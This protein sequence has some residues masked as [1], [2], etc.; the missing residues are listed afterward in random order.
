MNGASQRG[1]ASGIRDEVQNR[2][3]LPPIVSDRI[4]RAQI[5]V[6]SERTENLLRGKRD[7]IWGDRGTKASGVYAISYMPADRDPDSSHDITWYEA[8]HPDWVARTCAGE[9]ANSF[10]YPRGYLTPLLVA[11]ADVREYLFKDASLALGGDR[12][13][14]LGVDNLQSVNRWGRC[15]SNGVKGQYSGSRFD[16]AYVA[17]QAEWLRW[18]KSRAHSRGKCLAG[19]LHFNRGDTQGFVTLEKDL[20]IVIDEGGFTRDCRPSVLGKDWLTRLRLFATVASK[21]ALVLIDKI[22]PTA[23]EVTSSA[24]NWSVANYLLIKEDRTYLAINPMDTKG[25]LSDFPA[26][27]LKVGNALGV[28]EQDGPL[29]YRRYSSAL[30]LVNPSGGSAKFSLEGNRYTTLDGA[31]VEDSVTVAPGSALVLS[32]LSS[33]G[34]AKVGHQR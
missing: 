15:G 32:L 29:F 23:R 33:S 2:C 20:D 16:P 3:V 1:L 30:A 26:L 14:A 8:N 34:R 24:L 5:F 4:G 6:D 18:L 9:P 13:Q 28:F 27:Y 17:D 21:K 19:N 22:C 7:I 10:R 11:R 12:Y 25:R 31:T